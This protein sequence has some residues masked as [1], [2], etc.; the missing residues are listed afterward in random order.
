MTDSLTRILTVSWTLSHSWTL[1]RHLFKSLDC[2]QTSS[3]RYVKSGL[4]PA[5]PTASRR[6]PRSGQLVPECSPASRSGIE[7]LK[8]AVACTIVIAKKPVRLPQWDAEQAGS[9]PVPG[10][11]LAVPHRP[12]A[13]ARQ[14]TLSGRLVYNHRRRVREGRGPAVRQARQLDPVVEPRVDGDLRACHVERGIRYQ[15]GDCVADVDRL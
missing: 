10:H 9:G 1:S 13:R 4:N 11:V 14:A 3:F 6:A 7:P 12:Q 8:Q 2:M 5:Y 15:P